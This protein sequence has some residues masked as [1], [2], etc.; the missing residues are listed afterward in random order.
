MVNGTPV[1]DLK[2][3]IERAKI[4]IDGEL[5]E[6]LAPEE[7]AVGDRHRV[8]AA[9]RR[10][11]ELLAKA[12]LSDAEDSELGRIVHELSDRIMVGVPHDLRARLADGHRLDVLSLFFALLLNRSL[13]AVGMASRLS[14]ESRR[15]RS[16]KSKGGT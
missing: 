16:N 6:V 14:G 5:Y 9:G 1:L 10:V 2:T 7:L 8:L 15:P 13:G 3:S 11:D 12:S 4:K